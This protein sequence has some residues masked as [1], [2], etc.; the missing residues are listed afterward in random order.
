MI[1]KYIEWLWLS[2]RLLLGP[3]RLYAI[4]LWA[5]SR[6]GRDVYSTPASNIAWNNV[7]DEVWEWPCNCIYLECLH[8]CL[9]V[10]MLEFREHTCLMF[11]VVC[12]LY[13]YVPSLR[14]SLE[15]Y[16]LHLPL[17]TLKSILRGILEQD[18]VF[19]DWAETT[20]T[21]AEGFHPQFFILLMPQEGFWTK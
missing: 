19:S 10:G 8:C 9:L 4:F 12:L 1:R 11:A 5:K 2:S 15:T 7:H 16:S 20:T 17:L 21:V 18:R 13:L 3:K 6:P 14:L